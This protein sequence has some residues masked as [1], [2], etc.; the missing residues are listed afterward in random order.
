MSRD[1]GTLAARTSTTPAEASCP[2]TAQSVV[3]AEVVQVCVRDIR[4]AADIGVHQHEIGRRQ[5][6]IVCVTAD[7]A[8]GERDTLSST[9]DYNSIVG[10]AQGLANERICLIENFAAKLADLCLGSPLVQ[11]VE[12][13][14]E[15]PGAL[16]NGIAATRVVKRA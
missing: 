13:S 2:R 1:D 5:A 12:I 3:C 9:F 10:F 8:V 14:V 11:R 6:L 16:A 15:K 4:L 7:V